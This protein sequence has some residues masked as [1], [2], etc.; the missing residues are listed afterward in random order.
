MESLNLWFSS[1]QWTSTTTALQLMRCQTTCTR[2][3]NCLTWHNNPKV[4]EEICC[5]QVENHGPKC[6]NHH[7]CHDSLQELHWN[8]KLPLRTP[9]TCTFFLQCLLKLHYLNLLKC[10]SGSVTETMNGALFSLMG[11]IHGKVGIWIV[12]PF[13][14]TSLTISKS[15]SK[16][17]IS[18]YFI[19]VLNSVLLQFLGLFEI[20][21]F[22]YIHS[23][24]SISIN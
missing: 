12:F 24:R 16:H 11:Y 5:S 18:K 9:P 22:V 10:F 17:P 2:Y 19:R 14:P 7:S 15:S 23:C 6:L 20:H 4:E 3:L 8:W 13:Y 21:I 1:Q